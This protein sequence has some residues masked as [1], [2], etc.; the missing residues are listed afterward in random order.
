MT[1]YY[2]DSDVKVTSREWSRQP[3]HGHASLSFARGMTASTGPVKLEGLVSHSSLSLSHSHTLS[4]SLTLLFASPLRHDGRSGL[5]LLLR[6]KGPQQVCEAQRQ[7]AR[8]KK[9]ASCIRWGSLETSYADM[10]PYQAVR[11]KTDLG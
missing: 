5:Q 4:L 10:E 11:L 6:I 3:L 1:H 7:E 2:H 9:Q 8:R